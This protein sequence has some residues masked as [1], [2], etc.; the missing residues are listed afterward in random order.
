MAII[1]RLK[2][3]GLM[4]RSDL[5]WCSNTNFMVKRANK[6]LWCLKRLKRLGANTQDLLDVYCK[7]IRSIL[8]FGAPVWHPNLTSR[9]RGKEERVQKSAFCIILGRHFKSYNKALK[10][11]RMDS[12]FTR[13][14]KVCKKFA[15]KS[16]KHPSFTKWFKP[17]INQLTSRRK[18]PKFMEVFSRTKRFEK[19]PINFLINILNNG[20]RS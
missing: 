13:R 15:V 6:K 17:Q 7:Q 19:S 20:S 3:L 12:L 9:D 14:E 16:Q 8:E 10:S 4:I 11:L 5:S 1:Q 18:L 2:K